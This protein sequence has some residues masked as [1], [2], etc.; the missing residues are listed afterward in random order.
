MFGQLGL[1]LGSD[2][3]SLQNTCLHRMQDGCCKHFG[4]YASASKVWV[5]NQHI[6]IRHSGM[7]FLLVGLIYISVYEACYGFRNLLTML[8]YPYRKR[9]CPL[10]PP[11]T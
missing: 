2:G 10:R 3:I 5:P 9:L 8:F 7:V 4:L 11:L 1:K 6:L